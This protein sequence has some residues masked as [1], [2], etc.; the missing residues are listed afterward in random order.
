MRLLDFAR[1]AITVAATVVVEAARYI[2]P[3]VKIVAV[4]A[5]QIVLP[6]IVGIVVQLV[7]DIVDI[8]RMAKDFPQQP[9]P[10][11]SWA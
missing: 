9:R 4:T 5:F 8:H 1:S 7:R 2:A 11:R 10:R 6:L 3:V